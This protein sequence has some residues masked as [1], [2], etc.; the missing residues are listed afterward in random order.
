MWRCVMGA[1]IQN[2]KRVLNKVGLYEPAHRIWLK[3]PE[4]RLALY[5]IGYRLA[6]SSDRVPIPPT[7]LIKL[8]QINGEIS[9]FLR[10]G[11]LGEN[12][13]NNAL[14]ASGYHIENFERILDFGCGCGRILRHWTWTKTP[15]FYGTDLNPDL[16]H[17]CQHKLGKIA[18]FKLNGLEPPLD[19]PDEY[20]DLIYLIS[21]FTHLSEAVQEEWM[22]EFSRVLKKNGLLLI[23]VHG[24]WRINDLTPEEKSLFNTGQLVVKYEDLEGSNLC[25]AYHPEAY[26]KKH[27]AKDFE[28][29]SFL[30][31]GAI[32]VGQDLYL[33]KK[34]T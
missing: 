28:V 27:F 4:F 24:Q 12:S 22:H 34:I 20:F 5:N 9:V 13:I 26:M 32:D 15:H 17:W 31:T 3:R 33:L 25:G 21:V 7:R 30:A 16:I 14:L 23:T 1:V 19:F 18:E 29:Q 2:A 6:G 10:G 11:E 8:V